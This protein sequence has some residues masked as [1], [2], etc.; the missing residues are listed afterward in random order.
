LRI[1]R[2]AKAQALNRDLVARLGA[3]LCS[4]VRWRQSLYTLDDMGATTYVVLGPGSVLYGTT[5]RTVDGSRTLSVAS[6]NELD[7]L[8]ASLHGQPA[9]PVGAHEGEHLFATERVVVSPAA[10]VFRPDPSLEPG[11]ALDLGQVIGRVGD[12]E[13]VSSFTGSVVGVLARVPLDR[14]LAE[15]R[16]AATF[17]QRD[18]VN[19]VPSSCTAVT[20]K[21]WLPWDT[22]MSRSRGVTAPAG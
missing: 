14:L 12:H 6:P 20:V 11:L 4:P 21:R 8:L 15:A 17:T 9:E 16:G 3:Q 18:A 13:V 10:G 5:R 1:L 22:G 19:W 7:R 2:G